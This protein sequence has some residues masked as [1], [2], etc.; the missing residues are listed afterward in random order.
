MS[1][2]LL[3]LISSGLTLWLKGRCDRIGD[4]DL[5]LRGSGFGLLRDR[6]AG[7]NLTARDVLFKGC[8]CSTSK[9]TARPLPWT[10]T[11]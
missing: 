8:R 4:L 5:E 9:S 11:C 2:P 6:L 7:V 10:S 3:R 1:D